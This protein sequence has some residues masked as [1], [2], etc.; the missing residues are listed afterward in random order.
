MTYRERL[1]DLIAKSGM[2]NKEVAEKCSE[3]GVDI[4]ANY[5]GILRTQDKKIA[6]DEVSMAIATICNAKYKEILVVHAGLERAP[7]V[8]NDFV[9][10]LYD[11]NIGFASAA[12]DKMYTNIPEPLRDQMKANFDKN[13]PQIDK[14]TFVCEFMRGMYDDANKVLLN[15]LELITPTKKKWALIPINSATDVTVLESDEIVIK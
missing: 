8:I 2:T 1:N 7:A 9:D 15:Q 13:L 6:S 12:F 5:I 10:R 14:A 11:T 4:T 3:L